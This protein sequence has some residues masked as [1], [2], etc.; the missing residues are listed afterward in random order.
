VKLNKKKKAGRPNLLGET[1]ESHRAT[2]RYPLTLWDQICASA[3]ERD[4][5]VSD[6]LREAAENELKKDK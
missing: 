5:N 2:T 4:I 3:R 1:G 6:W